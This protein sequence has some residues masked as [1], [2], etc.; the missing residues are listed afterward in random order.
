MQDTK[1]IISRLVLQK[2]LQHEVCK[3][4]DKPRYEELNKMF[5]SEDPDKEL[6]LELRIQKSLIDRYYRSIADFSLRWFTDDLEKTDPE[7]NVWKVYQLKITSNISS[8][9]NA[10]VQEFIERAECVNA[11]AGLLSDLHEMAGYPIQVQ[12]LSSDERIAREI[13]RKYDTA[14]DE[15]CKHIRWQA[16]ELRR[17]LRLGGKARTFDRERFAKIKV[18]PGRYEF[19]INDGS[20][21]S[22]KYKKY[23]ITIPENPLF[24]CAIRRVS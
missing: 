2:V 10:N 18:E 11:L 5:L 9:W 15:I 1:K 21:K 8:R 24:L 14:C 4:L 13:K 3:F 16:P 19:D 23:S 7:G 12:T 20:A 22:P 17:G 6:K